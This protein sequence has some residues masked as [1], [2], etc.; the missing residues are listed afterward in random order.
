MSV[1]LTDMHWSGWSSGR[2]TGGVSRARVKVVRGL[3]AT[4]LLHALRASLSS[5]LASRFQ[6]AIH[7]RSM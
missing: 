6:V 5:P 1:P 2:I 4:L 7:P 3:M